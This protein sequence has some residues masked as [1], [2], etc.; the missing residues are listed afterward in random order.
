MKDALIP[1]LCCPVTNSRL[2]L[3][4]AERDSTT[5]EIRSGT[6]VSAEG[7]EY[8]I[9]DG[10]PVLSLGFRNQDEA[11]T[12]QSFGEE[13]ARYDDFDG[14][15][16]SADLFF[17][18]TGLTGEQVRGRTILEVGCGGGRW[19]AVMAELGAREVVG[20]DFSSATLQASRRTAAYTQVH[21]VRG[22]SLAM[23]LLPKFDLVVSIGVVHHLDDPVQGLREMRKVVAPSHLVAIWVYAREGNELYLQMVKPLRW[24]GPKLPEPLLVGVS[25]SLAAVVWSYMHTLNRVAVRL[26][27]RTPMRDYFAMLAKLRFRDVESVVYD[28]LTPSIARYPTQQ[29]VRAWVSQA[30]GTIASLSQRSGNSWR[31]HFAFNDARTAV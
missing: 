17:Q 16:G 3:D 29:E 8:P 23:P 13:W 24:I 6:L 5:G 11:Q 25:R 21:V 27:L 19:L 18:F 14:Y 12:V 2:R 15:M 22:S 26:A 4:V 9:V 20:L 1:F 30:G 31:C 10:I 7:R 28:Q